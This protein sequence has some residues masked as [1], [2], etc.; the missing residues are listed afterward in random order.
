MVTET[1]DLD[2]LGKHTNIDTFRH[3]WGRR[4]RTAGVEVLLES[5]N[6]AEG[7]I[8]GGKELGRNILKNVKGVGF[9][10]IFHFYEIATSRRKIPRRR[11]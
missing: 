7:L 9:W 10:E 11:F 5:A 4:N 8:Q 1:S 6:I 3:L 2:F